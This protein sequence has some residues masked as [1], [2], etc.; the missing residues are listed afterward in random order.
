MSKSIIRKILGSAAVA[1]VV[2]IGTITASP[3]AAHAVINPG[4]RP[5]VYPA[6]Q[7]YPT[8]SISQS[9]PTHVTVTGSGFTSGGQVNV[10]GLC[11][12]S[13]DP[14]NGQFVEHVLTASPSGTFSNSFYIGCAQGNFYGYAQNVATNQQSNAPKVS[15][16]GCL[17]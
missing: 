9:D 12:C 8:I 2:G 6:Q 10:W 1:T 16:Y 4:P 15:V 5:V 17:Y 14:N 11:Q 13:Y 7:V 3:L